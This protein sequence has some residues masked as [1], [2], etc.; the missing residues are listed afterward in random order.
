MPLSE[1]NT[2]MVIQT[3]KK[4]ILASASPRRKTLIKHL[5]SDYEVVPSSIN[6]DDYKM[7]SP[8]EMPEFL[9]AEKAKNIAKIYT[10][11]IVI[12]CDTSVVLGERVLGKPKDETQARNMLSLLSNKTHKVITG[13][14]IIC[15]DKSMSFSVST[16]VTFYELD[17]DEI[18]EYVQSGEP[19]DKAGGY[20]IQGLGSVFVKEISGDF[21]NVVGLPVSRLYREMIEFLNFIDG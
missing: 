2:N 5:F 18:D 14:C 12:G 10:D 1:H 21:Y 13:V 6:E 9:A 11:S 3:D 16:D 15:G 4:V 8:Y 17:D 7:L 20:G 19:Y